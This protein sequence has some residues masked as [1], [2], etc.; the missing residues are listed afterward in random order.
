MQS[1]KVDDP[2][3]TIR[4]QFRD[5]NSY[6]CGVKRDKHRKLA[7]AISRANPACAMSRP[8]DWRKKAMMPQERHLAKAI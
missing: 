5:P 7:L 6:I 1:I 8:Y 3:L 4:K 2:G